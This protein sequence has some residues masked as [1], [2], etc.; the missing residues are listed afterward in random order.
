MN[1]NFFNDDYSLKNKQ[2][3]E[4]LL[5]PKREEF[6]EIPNVNEE[7]SLTAN[8]NMA[9]N[10][11]LTDN[12][13]ESA[14]E[15]QELYKNY[16]VLD[17]Q[18][19]NQTILDTFEDKPNLNEIG[20][21]KEVKN[22][23]PYNLFQEFKK[24]DNFNDSIDNIIQPSILSGVF[25]SRKNI[26]NI[27]T[28][29]ISGIKDIMNYDIG[30]QSEDELQTIM[31]SIYLQFSKNSDCEIQKQIKQL[32]SEVLKYCIYNVYTNAKQYLGYLVDINDDKKYYNFPPSIK[33]NV[34]SGDKNAYRLD[35]LINFSFSE[36]YNI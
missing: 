31:R 19:K 3:F 24:K 6:R 35:S 4:T 13:D 32:N 17:M 27:Q 36:D 8:F 20:D 14:K 15:Y 5:D 30:N 18:F 34:K 12:M 29:I 22:H 10:T 28:K 2:I 7:E 33:T 26:N 11:A 1:N 16:N 9:L 25:F 23:V 21:I